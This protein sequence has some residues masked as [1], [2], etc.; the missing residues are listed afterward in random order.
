MALLIAQWGILHQY[1]QITSISRY[2]SNY[3]NALNQ[4]SFGT[5]TVFCSK[6]LNF[7]LFST[8]LLSDYGTE[9]KLFFKFIGT[10]FKFVLS[11]QQTSHQL[12]H[13]PPKDEFNIQ[14]IRTA[15]NKL[16]LN[17]R[18]AHKSQ[19]MTAKLALRLFEYGDM[20]PVWR[21]LSCSLHLPRQFDS[22]DFYF[23]LLLLHYFISFWVA[24]TVF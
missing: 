3:G 21:L 17:I 11:F 2:S 1:I 15:T 12:F 16:W 4:Q 18:T 20:V 23:L 8:C 6:N 14:S 19:T 22:M 7:S 13:F 24:R 9:W 5:T 10:K